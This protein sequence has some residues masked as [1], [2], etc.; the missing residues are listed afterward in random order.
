MTL[1]VF[2][3]IASVGF[4]ILLLMLVFGADDGDVD[5]GFDADD[6]DSGSSGAHWLSIKVVTSF[7]TGFG[8]SGAIATIY[9]LSIIQSV[10]IGLVCGLI[11]AEI[12]RLVL[13][14]F[15][16]QQTT[17]SY[18][19]HELVNK[20]GRVTVSI[21]PGSIGW[22]SVIHNG[23]SIVRAANTTGSKEIR[24]GEEVIIVSA[25]PTQFLVEKLVVRKPEV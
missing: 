14:F 13:R 17:S 8:A 4:I 3:G 9:K 20:K 11:L 21:I 25:T 10:V 19:A 24:A 2:L 12:I 7:M 6:G 1:L 18:S 15:Y 23:I 5:G 16:S 22:V